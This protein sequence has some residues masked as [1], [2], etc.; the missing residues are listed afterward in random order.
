MSPYVYCYSSSYVVCGVCVVCSRSSRVR[1][2]RSVVSRMISVV[3]ISVFRVCIMIL[4]L[5]VFVVVF[6]LCVVLV[7]CVV[8]VFVASVSYL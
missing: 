6:V 7:V 2:C 1:I 5:C 8:S 4:V 3:I